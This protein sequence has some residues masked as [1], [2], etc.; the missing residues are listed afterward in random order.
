MIQLLGFPLPTGP[1]SKCGHDHKK[2]ARFSTS[3]RGLFCMVGTKHVRQPD[4]SW[5]GC[6]GEIP[7]EQPGQ[8]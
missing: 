7:A 1:C 6:G 3:K 2:D 8:G 5:D 4:G